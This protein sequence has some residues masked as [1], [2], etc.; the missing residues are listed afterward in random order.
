MHE[1]GHHLNLNHASD[2]SESHGD[3]TGLMGYSY[4]EES[5]TMCFNTAKSWQLGWYGRRRITLN[6]SKRGGFN[7]KLIGIDDYQD[8]G[9]FGKYTIIKVDNSTAIQ[10]NVFVGFNYAAGINSG[11][12]EAKNQVTV[13][14]QSTYARSFLL[15]KLGAGDLYSLSN[16]EGGNTLNVK[17]KSINLSASPPVADVDIFLSACPPGTCGAQCNSCCVDTDCNGADSCANG[18]CYEGSCSYDTSTCPGNFRL[19]LTTDTFPLETSWDIVDQCSGQI[20]LSGG[21]YS[22]SNTLY[23]NTGTIGKSWYK[24]TF[25]DSK[26]NGMG[27]GA[28]PGSVFATFDGVEVAEGGGDFGKQLIF[29]FG[30]ECTAPVTPAPV[31]PTPAP[32]TPT[33]A[34][35]VPTP[36]PVTPTPAPEA[37]T[38][39]PV[40]PTPAP[41]APTPAPVTPTPAPVVPTP[42]PV[43][44]TPAPVAPTP[45]PVTPTPA[46]VVPTP[47]PVTPTPAPVALWIVVFQDGFESG[48]TIFAS[49]GK[50]SKIFT[51][52]DGSKSLELRDDKSS[53]TA[54]TKISYSV[55]AYS[56]VRVSFVFFTIDVDPNERFFLDWSSN[57]GSSWNVASTFTHRVD[58]ENN[59]WNQAQISWV[60]SSSSSVRL[61]FRSQFSASSERVLIDNV[62]LEAR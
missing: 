33:P 51:L 3:Q 38:P 15:A 40:T 20:K 5:T 41:V 21:S 32:V 12:K 50:E 19:D 6:F 16:F 4:G 26:G 45:A 25:R 10:P 8:A 24:L 22:S 34:P 48:F 28:V 57:N 58:F 60:V 29:Y 59:Q 36:A 11:T 7:G 35:V 31:A 47:A 13:H 30:T 43:T 52:S 2:G 27:S 1:I 46:P 56:E 17:V 39:A 37:P 9:S 54:S 18:W 62:K 61:R 14:T 23:T 42:A 49:G 44:P 53:S 55:T